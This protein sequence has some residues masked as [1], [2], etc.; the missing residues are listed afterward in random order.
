MIR[1]RY[2]TVAL[3]GAWRH[4]RGEAVQDALRA[5]QARHDDRAPDGAAWAVPGEIETNLT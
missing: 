3:V 2:R 5:G 1:H 4:S